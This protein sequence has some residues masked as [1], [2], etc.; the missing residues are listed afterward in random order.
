M[1]D[2]VRVVG[3]TVSDRN[4]SAD[5]VERVDD[6]ASVTQP[7]KRRRVLSDKQLA[8]LS[9]RTRETMVTTTRTTEEKRRCR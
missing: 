2:E 1:N 5:V 6:Q 9:K 3:T 8:A 4:E 7:T